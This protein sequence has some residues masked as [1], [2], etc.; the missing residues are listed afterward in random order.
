[1]RFFAILIFFFKFS[2]ILIVIL[3]Y[4][5]TQKNVKDV[6]WMNLAGDSLPPWPRE[7]DFDHVFIVRCGF[8][9]YH[10]KIPR[11]FGGNTRLPLASYHCKPSLG[12]FISSRSSNCTHVSNVKLIVRIGKERRRRKKAT[13]L[14][15]LLRM[16]CIHV[17]SK[18]QLLYNSCVARKKIQFTTTPEKIKHKKPSFLSP[19]SSQSFRQ[20]KPFHL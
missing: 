3:M 11:N 1:M 16:A 9:E 2:L 19:S 10:M 6:E 20:K 8:G 5:S 17:L 7:K 13:K 12:F 18:L 14:S 15:W 4:V